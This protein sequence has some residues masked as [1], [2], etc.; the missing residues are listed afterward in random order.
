MI[1]NIFVWKPFLFRL[2][3]RIDHWAKPATP[4]LISGALKDLTRTRTDLVIENALLRQQIIVLNRQVKRPLLTP[5]DRVGLI[6]LARCTRFWKQALHI[7]QPD[8]HLCWHRE[9]FC[10]YWRWKSK[11]KQKS[12]RF[13]L[14]QSSSSVRWQKRTT[15]GEQSGF[16]VNF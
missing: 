11:N 3:Q 9:L 15:Y 10:F 7:V 5:R 1:D 13:H 12:Q 14:K 4:S 2:Q 16:R 8:T 6:L